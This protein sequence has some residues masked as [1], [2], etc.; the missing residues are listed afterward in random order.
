MLFSAHSG[1]D[2]GM[3]RIAMAALPLAEQRLDVWPPPFAD[4]KKALLPGWVY[5]QLGPRSPK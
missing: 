1:E 5:T 3:K 4:P 2:K